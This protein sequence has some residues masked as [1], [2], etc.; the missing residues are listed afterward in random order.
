MPKVLFNKNDIKT[1]KTIFKT[2]T[3]ILIM[4]IYL[5]LRLAIKTFSKSGSRDEV[6]AKTMKATSNK[7]FC[8]IGSREED[9]IFKPTI[10]MSVVKAEAPRTKVMEKFKSRL[11]SL[12]ESGRK[13]II[14]IESPKSAIRLISPIEDMAAEESPTAWG[15]YNLAATIRKTKFTNPLIIVPMITNEAFFITE[16]ENNW[17]LAI[18]SWFCIS[19]FNYY[20]LGTAGLIL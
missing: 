11:L 15:V 1:I 6:R 9:H 8:L 12:P 18:L 4:G 17:F 14:A 7:A 5:V 20:A 2:L 19:Y 3:T 16:C 13:R 10:K